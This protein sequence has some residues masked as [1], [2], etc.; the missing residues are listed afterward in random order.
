[1]G[2]WLPQ[3]L[4][5][6]KMAPLLFMFCLC[7]NFQLQEKSIFVWYSLPEEISDNKVGEAIFR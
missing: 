1:M 3:V 4:S 2:E 6:A 5:G 7:K